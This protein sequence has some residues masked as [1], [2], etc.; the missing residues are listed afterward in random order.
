VTE[1]RRRVAYAALIAVAALA[2]YAPARALPF[3]RYDDEQ[4]V[5]ANPAV[6]AGLGLDGVRWAFTT[7]HASNWHPLTWLSHML[8]V[9]LFGTSAAGPHLENALLHALNSALVFAVLVRLTGA[10][11][12]SALA[13]ALF[14]VH[15]QHVES[16]AWVAERKDLLCALF[17]LLALA[18][19]PSWTRG[20]SRLA[21]GATL[22]CMALGLLAKPM[23]VS[24]PLLLLV[25]DFWPLARPWRPRLVLEKLPFAALSLGSSWVTMRA[26]VH[27]M[28]LDVPF[29]ERAANA[30]VALAATLAQ[31][32]APL[33]LAVLYPHPF[34]SHWP[35]LVVAVAFGGLAVLGAVA[36]ALRRRAPYLAAGGLWFA[37]GLGPT[38][39]LVQVGFQSYADRYAYL[40]Q[41]GVAWA[42]V[43]GAAHL[44]ARMR[45]P[46]LAGL[47]LAG[48]AAL[49]LAVVT[50]VQIRYW[51]SDVALWSRA[52]D[53]ARP[54]YYA[55]TELGIEL[56]VIGRFAESLPHFA[57]ALELNPR[58]PRAQASYGFALFLTGDTAGAIE[59]F[60]RAFEIQPNA[61]AGS[62]W[63]LYFARALAAAGRP[64]EAAAHYQTQLS[65]DPNDPGAL[66]GLAEIR[67]T[68]P[69][70]PLRDGAEALALAKRGC[71]I[72]H[73]AHPAE[74]DILALA[75]AAA[76]DSVTAVALEE[77]ALRRV[78]PGE[79]AETV[80]R[81]QANLAHFRAGQAVTRP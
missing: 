41:I 14:A 73:C 77:E 13:A 9:S 81:I 79:D 37:I 78:R 43:W 47:A 69:G 40:P 54:S 23:L 26:Q 12:R 27:A 62:E 30:C 48:A 29:A 38:L 32:F 1:S 2:L 11:G 55:E 49:A 58:W 21:Y 44:L 76:G 68:H 15:P 4:Y 5:T 75:A 63:H 42:V 8:D 39:G 36:L 19:W 61:N 53:V 28:Q 74:I 18:A 71:Q 31:T 3:L 34:P 6:Q 16:V 33:R 51:E 72:A 56:G 67:A 46:R 66:L 10:S 59:R 50:H 35:P 45:A 20:G 24:L 64:E 65:M 60:E 80:A 22:A 70:P 7:F 25:L 17:A 52:V 57:R